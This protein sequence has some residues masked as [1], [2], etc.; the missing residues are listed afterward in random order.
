MQLRYQPH[1]N[2]S[3]VRGKGAQPAAKEDNK[4]KHDSFITFILQ[5]TLTFKALGW[6]AQMHTLSICAIAHTKVI[7]VVWCRSVLNISAE[8]GKLPPN[9]TG[10][11][12]PST[13][14]GTALQQPLLSTCFICCIRVYTN[15][16]TYFEK[17]QQ[18]A[19]RRASA[20]KQKLLSHKAKQVGSWH[21]K[22]GG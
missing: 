6:C 7:F 5:F 15:F 19:C 1:Q 8:M 9:S 12:Y 11:V 13:I 18:W 20:N 16:I 2:S 3:N 10:P 14:I 21:T 22:N 17:I 4:R